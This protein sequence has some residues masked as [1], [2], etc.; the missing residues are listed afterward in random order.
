MEGKGRLEGV[1][2]EEGCSEEGTTVTAEDWK[3][4]ASA[5][6]VRQGRAEVHHVVGTRIGLA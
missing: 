5:G 2:E 3:V 4:H 6:V 1:G